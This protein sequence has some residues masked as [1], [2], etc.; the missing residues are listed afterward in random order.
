M[1]ATLVKLEQYVTDADIHK[2]R[3]ELGLATWK[4]G[5]H[6]SETR[7]EFEK[8][9]LRRWEEE[10]NRRAVLLARERADESSWKSEP[11]WTPETGAGMRMAALAQPF[12]TA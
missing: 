12:P 5:S 10:D 3:C 7:E 8:K 4:F 9:T 11:P 6:G 1:N 2:R